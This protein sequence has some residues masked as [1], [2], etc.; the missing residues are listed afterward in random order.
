M[1]IPQIAR[2]RGLSTTTVYSH[3][4][5]LIEQGHLQL[6]EVVQLPQE[7]LDNIVDVLLA[8]SGEAFKLKPVYEE[9][10]G[11]YDYDVLRCVYASLQAE[12]SE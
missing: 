6:E 2:H 8:H 5:K 11:A 10:G 3:I 7:E 9:L 4:T 1:D 12:I